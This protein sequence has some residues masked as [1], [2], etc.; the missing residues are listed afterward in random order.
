MK[1]SGSDVVVDGLATEE[2]KMKLNTWQLVGLVTLLACLVSAG[3]LCIAAAMRQKTE[4]TSASLV[5]L[6]NGMRTITN[7]LAYG[8]LRGKSAPPRDGAP[9]EF[10]D[11]TIPRFNLQYAVPSVLYTFS[12]NIAF[13]VLAKINPATFSIIW[14]CKTAVVAVLMRVV[15]VR[16]PFT[17]AKW[18][19]VALL[20][21]GPTLVEL[22][23]KREAKE[24][25][26]THTPV[27]WHLL[28]LCGAC[29]SAAANVYTE[30][31]LKKFKHDPFFW[32]NV[33]LYSFSTVFTLV[34]LIHQQG[35]K[36]ALDLASPEF[37]MTHVSGMAILAML[38]QVA[39]A[40][41]VPAILKFADNIADLFAH[42]GAVLITAY[43]SW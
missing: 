37:L 2:C 29:I 24:V 27:Y 16:K 35:I 30:W 17:W 5:F 40:F 7:L 26:Q 36:A 15:L 11:S 12:D 18:G 1:H 39:Q 28:C 8:P 31:V 41:L 9:A 34:A 21:I 20:L 4:L 32:Q 42:A 3:G 33:Q 22:G 19:G 14:N 25:G 43:F 6:I 13:M 23:T 38:M 10:N